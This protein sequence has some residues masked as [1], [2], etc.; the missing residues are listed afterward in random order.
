M[1]SRSPSLTHPISSGLDLAEMNHTSAEEWEAWRASELAG[2][3]Y[4]LAAHDFWGAFRPDVLKRLRRQVVQH[5]KLGGAPAL[6]SLLWIHQYVIRGSVT[7][8]VDHIRSAAKVGF[9]REHVVD[10]LAIAFLHA[11]A[12]QMSVVASAA[13]DALHEYPELAAEP[14]LYPDAW[15]SDIAV[16]KSGADFD[17]PHPSPEDIAAIEEWYRR[18]CGEIPRG[19]VLLAREHPG[20]LKAWRDRFE[21]A[22]SGSLPVQMIPF[23]FVAMEVE[24]ANEEGIRDALRLARG[25]GL[26]KGHALEALTWGLYYGGAGA[27]A[28]AERAGADI[29]TD[30]KDP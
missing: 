1:N 11:P 29:L 21:H 25:L 19:V 14:A 23:V 20:L 17:H 7:G 27:L 18:V 26:G 6:S 22:I 28:A 2:R 10:V 5:L 30:W 9:P 15:K 24:R 3:G 4:I 8:V 16:L 13:A 12:Y